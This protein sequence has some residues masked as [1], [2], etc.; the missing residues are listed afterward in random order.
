MRNI[1]IR[2]RLLIIM[3][4]AILSAVVITV[5]ALSS[6]N[7]VAGHVTMI[8]EY[9]VEQLSRLIEMFHSFD[10]LRRHLRDAVIA[11]DHDDIAFYID[12]VFK[13]YAFLT[14]KTENYI[15]HLEYMGTTYGEEFDTVMAF[16]MALPEAAVIVINIAGYA[17]RND[18]ERAL[19]YIQTQCVPFTGN[20]NGYLERLAEINNEQVEKTT[21]EANSMLTSSFLTMG[22]TA[23]LSI[24]ILFILITVIA[25][26]IN[27]PLRQMIEASDNIAEGN[28]NVNLDTNSR[29]ETG[30]LAKSF[31]L[32]IATIN[33]II[34]DLGEMYKMHEVEGRTSYKIDTS[35][36]SGAYK[37]VADGVNK[38]SASHTTMCDEI[39]GA[40]ENIAQGDF[41]VALPQYKGEKA[42][43]NDTVNKV[44]QKIKEVASSIDI[45]AK[46]C[47]QGDLTVKADIQKFTG[48]WK[49]IASSLDSLMY[50]V[51]TVMNDTNEALDYLARGDFSY[52]ITSQYIGGYEKMKQSANITSKSIESY[53][54]EVSRVLEHISEGDLT[55]EI[56]RDYAGDFASIKSSINKICNTLSLTMNRIATTSEQVHAGSAQIAIASGQI[57]NDALE[58]T[59]AIQDLNNSINNINTHT[60]E[61]STNAKH[62]ANLTDL[63]KKSAES[64]NEEMTALLDAINGIA[65]SSEKISKI[66]KT[67]QDIAFQTNL[68]ALNAAVEASRA[69]EH[70]KGFA[71]VA[72]EVRALAEKSRLAAEDTTGLIN[73]SMER[74][75]E[76]TSRA[77]QTAE[78][79]HQI[80]ANV[81]DVVEVVEKI[82]E[83]SI[84]QAEALSAISAGIDSISRTVQN[85]SA[86]SHQS[87]ASSEE[88]KSQ[89][90]TLKQM[91]G[92][93][94]TNS[95]TTGRVNI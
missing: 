42:E 26:S 70:G 11:T 88:L 49:E 33:E 30:T 31:A 45:F 55:H 22:L 83:A 32:L 25:N 77:N 34:G 92:F 36:F 23:A 73:E 94:K 48:E 43:I 1:K 85:S 16:K 7:R 29:D 66:V 93:F 18:A 20:M 39:L 81:V 56:Q 74:V 91:I 14:E 47:I 50:A 13:Q 57:A 35:K 40:M 4:V 78:S 38:M 54:S 51:S 27:K 9:N 37:E 84:L 19:F 87:A 2:T 8:N 76:G 80:V 60:Q 67:I 58:Q 59:N 68:L 71:V 72:E 44:V 63:S 61:S 17:E 82:H 69:G 5:S 65:V 52:R 79:L 3:V 64:G 86:S 41:S 90:E 15:A 46:A 12:S 53:I 24:I 62:A 95:L 10:T 75:Q 89:S 21:A 28:L 6:L